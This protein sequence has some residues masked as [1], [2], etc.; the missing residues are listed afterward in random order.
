MNSFCGCQVP[1]VRGTDSGPFCGVCGWPIR[2][3]E[4]EEC[5]CCGAWLEPRSECQL[6]DGTMGCADT[7]DFPCNR[8][9]KVV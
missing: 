8:H 3:M 6:C 9:R 4:V 2:P 5:E 7:G 1:D